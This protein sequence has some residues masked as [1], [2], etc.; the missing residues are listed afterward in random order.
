MRT[1]LD[2]PDEIFRKLKAEAALRGFKL[3]E[4]VTQFIERGLAADAGQPTPPR[5]RSPFPVAIARDLGT[6]MTP[7]LTN[8]QL[9]SILEEEDLAQYRSV[10]DQPRTLE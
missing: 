5:Q 6:P 3:K 7:A 1:T 4:L 9:H 2:L 8:E 10:I